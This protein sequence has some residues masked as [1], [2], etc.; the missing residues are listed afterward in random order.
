M[1]KWPN[2]SVVV[3]VY[4]AEQYIVKFAESLFS[5]SYPHLQFIFVNDGTKDRSIEVLRALIDDKYSHLRD[6]IIIVDKENGGVHTARKTG[7]GYVGGDY[8]YHCDPDDWLS[9]DAMQSIAN[10]AFETDADIIYFNFVKEYG[11]RSKVKAESVYTGDTKYEYVRNMYNHRAF[12]SLC[13]KCVKT[14]IYKDNVIHYPKYSYADDCYLS[15]Q[16]A[17]YSKKIVYLDKVLYHYRKNNPASITH[18]ARKGRK[19]EYILN[20]LNLYENYRNVPAETNPVAVIF[21]DILIQAGWYSMLYGLDLFTLYPYLA[22]DIR[23]AKVR[24][25]SDV[26]LPFQLLVKLISRFIH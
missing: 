13:N 8:I 26:W 25:G 19:R 7:I 15:V 14:S 5:Q 4:G 2:I 12:G 24:G 6:R 17:G 20:F 16:L 22:G 1:N 9:E 3:P 23:R 10:V 11:T 18:Q 21:D